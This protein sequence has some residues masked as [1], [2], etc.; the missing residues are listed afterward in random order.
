MISTTCITPS[1]KPTIGKSASMIP[2]CMV[3]TMVPLS[4]FPITIENLDTGATRI[5]FIKP[6]SLSHI[7]DIEEKIELKSIVIPIIPGKMNCVYDTPVSRGT[8]LDMPAPTMNNHKR[9]L[10]IAEKRRLFSLINFLSSL[11]TITYTA[12]NSIILYKGFQGYNF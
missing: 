1:L 4:A 10:A 8:S 5:S 2:A 12:L 3:D 7:M 6:N 9:G 11:A